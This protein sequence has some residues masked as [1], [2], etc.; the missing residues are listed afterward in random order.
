MKLRIC[1]FPLLVICL[2][3]VSATSVEK[4]DTSTGSELQV[5]TASPATSKV[6]KVPKLN[7]IQRLMLKL[8]VRKEKQ[9]ASLKA[10]RLA[11]TSLSLGIAAWAVFI[12]GLAAPILIFASIPLGIAAMITGSSAIKQGTPHKG[13]AKTGKGLGLGAMITLAVLLIIAA[14]AVSAMSFDFNWAGG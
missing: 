7:F 1:L 8:F 11:A 10:D 13:K 3:L 12:L 9:P 6:V 2:F 5:T 14:I 4:K